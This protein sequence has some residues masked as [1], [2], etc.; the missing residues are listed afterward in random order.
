MLKRL[1]IYR[2]RGA[3]PE[4]LILRIEIDRE[5]DGRWIVD[6]VDLPGVMCYGAS[7]DEAVANAAT[8]ALRIID[9]RVQHGEH[10]P[11]FASDVD[12]DVAP[13]LH[14]IHHHA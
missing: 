11:N 12:E 2:R 10:L 1:K 14:D 5:D 3:N 9:E 7:K 6:A 13:A 8:L 4:Q